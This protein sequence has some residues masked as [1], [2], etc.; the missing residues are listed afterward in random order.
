MKVIST[1]L[2]L[3]KILV[4]SNGI[5]NCVY[6]YGYLKLKSVMHYDALYIFAITT[7]NGTTQSNFSNHMQKTIS[8]MHS[9]ND[10]YVLQCIHTYILSL[11]QVNLVSASYIR[12]LILDT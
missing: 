2:Y 5:H 12:V 10:T 11:Y 6:T 7:K 9:M 1:V 3:I 4:N 8:T